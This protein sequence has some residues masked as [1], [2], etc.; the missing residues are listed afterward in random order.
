MTVRARGKQR[1][2][3]AIEVA[4]ARCANVRATNFFF[5]KLLSSTR[6]VGYY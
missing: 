4:I 2:R 6:A 3:G 5:A 1:H